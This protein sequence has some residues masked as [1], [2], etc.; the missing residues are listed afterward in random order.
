MS[1]WRVVLCLLAIAGPARAEDLPLRWKF[2]PGDSQRYLMT[3]TASLDLHLDGASGVVAEVHRVFDFEWSVESVAADGTASI[4]VR[5]TRVALRVVGPGRQETEYDTQSVEESRGFAATLAPL[6]KT[7][8]KS[9]LK[10]EMNPRGELSQ[11]QI[12]EDLQV[13]LD[14]KPPGKALGKLGSKDDFRSLLQLGLP[15]FPESD[16]LAVG[17]QWEEDRQLENVAIGK[18]TAHTVYQWES[19]RQHE[20]EQLAVIVPTISIRLT[21]SPLRLTDPIAGDQD[22]QIVGE[23]NTGEILFNLTAGRLQ[24]SRIELQLELSTPDGGQSV[25]GTLVHTLAFER[26]D[27]AESN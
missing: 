13:L 23:K 25:Y 14:S 6:F 11:L 17:Q 8:L 27:E 21:D 5:V 22:T 7:L 19:I 12:P 26:L 4:S 20:G 15:A 16:S 18:P 2:A 24:S 9:E 3:Q 10:A 1:I